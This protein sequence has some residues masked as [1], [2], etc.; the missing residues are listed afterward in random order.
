MTFGI[1]FK[2]TSLLVLLSAFITH[3]NTMQH[4]DI[5]DN[6]TTGTL[7]SHHGT[8][9][10]LVTD[11]VMG[12]VSQ[13]DLQPERI[14]GRDCLRL[15]GVVSTANNG[16][17]VQ[18]ALDIGAS[19]PFDAS[20]FQGL[21]LEVSGNGEEY[22]L[23]LRTADLWLPW[24][25]YRYS[26]VAESDWRQIRVPFTDLD[27]YRTNIRFNPKNLSRIGLV[28]IGREFQADLCLGD[29]RFYSS[30]E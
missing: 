28:A 29:I 10:R 12:G 19:G 23:H 1:H 21:L 18:M 7:Y 11:G 22:N 26:F 9:W 5:I 15:Q 13:G 27:A 4:K 3:G 14:R 16:G 30:V 6:R 20:L 25:S 17:F 8:V 24:Q 2:L